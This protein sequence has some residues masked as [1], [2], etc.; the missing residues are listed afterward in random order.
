MRD[1]TPTDPPHSWWHWRPRPNRTEVRL[2]RLVAVVLVVYA[3]NDVHVVDQLIYNGTLVAASV[4]AWVGA[5]RAPRG[6]RLAPRL[7]A[8]GVSL[9]TLGDLLW[10]LLD[11]LGLP[12]DV[13]IA[14]AAW[15]A[16]Y[17]ALCAAVWLVLAR[18]RPRGQHD[19][20]FLVDALTII[21]VSVVVFWNLTI[22][23]ILGLE[24]LTP[25][26]KAV[27]AAYPVLD[28]V[29]LALVVRALLSG[30]A[31]RSIDTTFAVGVVVWLLADTG[32]LVL[33]PGDWSQV[34]IDAGWMVAP[35]LLARA[36]WSVR[37]HDGAPEDDD[38]RPSRS[39][40]LVIAIAP[41]FVPP[42]LEVVSILTGR[43]SRPWTL[44]IGSTCLIALT[45]VR[46]ARLMLADERQTRELVAARDAALDASRA[47]SLFVGTMSHEVRTPLT[48]LVGTMEMLG[49]TDLDDDQRFLV[50]RMGRASTR[51]DSLME[52]VLDFSVIEAGSLVLVDRPFDLHK[53][54]DDV[55]MIH[56]PV[57]LRAGLRV[58]WHCDADV[59]ARVVGDAP[60]LQRVLGNLLDNAVKFTPG[61]SVGMRVA[62]VGTEP[63]GGATVVLFSVADT[64]IGIPEDRLADVFDCFTQADGSPTRPYEG[65]G[66]G[67]TV[68]R[69]LAEAMG[70]SLS[71]RSAPGQGSTFEVSVPLRRVGAAER[72]PAPAGVE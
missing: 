35:V 38:T 18:S 16:S 63:A 41:L 29:L 36:A 66:L 10:T 67:L 22:P 64:G 52:D 12:T 32:P 46:T 60:R 21:V 65:L 28:A 50:E 9:S 59:P 45:F 40:A 31:R 25:F 34:A 24:D 33:P 68:S 72:T 1:T 53:A 39:A 69:R 7:I 62:T 17:V 6:A 61:G 13:S 2:A 37:P 27:W 71:V 44:T 70:G 47:K 42:G 14:D 49:D 56:E 15:F 8:L 23:S 48:T 51:L 57:A 30:Q 11:A 26:A 54:L 55:R 5:R 20:G 58:E 3:T 43:E 4:A 19:V